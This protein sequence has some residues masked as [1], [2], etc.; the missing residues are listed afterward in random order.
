LYALIRRARAS[1]RGEEQQDRE[2]IRS[3]ERALAHAAKRNDGNRAFYDA[4][5]ALNACQSYALEKLGKSRSGALTSW[6]WVR[7]DQS[8]RASER[9]FRRAGFVT[10]ALSA[11]VTQLGRMSLVLQEIDAESQI[12]GQHVETVDS[13]ATFQSSGNRLHAGISNHRVNPQTGYSRLPC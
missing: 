13:D 6:R 1:G 4:R 11:T 2:D 10:D 7:E 12:S 9:P 8:S 5:L 3:P